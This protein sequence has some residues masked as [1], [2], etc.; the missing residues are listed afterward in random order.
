MDTNTTRKARIAL[1]G[2]GRIGRTLFRLNFELPEEEQFD[3]VVIKD[4]IPI[5]NMA[6]LLGHDSSY[7]NFP[8][9]IGFDD[10]NL[11]IGEQK[12]PYV[13]SFNMA[14]VDWHSYKPDIL[15]EASGQATA[16][17]MRSIIGGTITN[18]VYGRNVNDPDI[19]IVC[20]VNEH[21]YDPRN[22][23]IVSASSCTGN[24]LLPIVDV[25]LPAFGIES[26][27]AVSIHPV[28]GD[29]QLLDKSHQKFQLGRNAMRSIISTSSGIPKSV[30][31]LFPE[32]D[33]KVSAITYRVPTSIVSV[34]D[35]SMTLKKPGT[36]AE[37]KEALFDASNEKYAGI[38]AF[39]EGY[40]GHSKVSIDF[41]KSPYS[42]I[43]MAP[44][45]AMVQDQLT[46]SLIHDNE[47][48]YC[49]R[50]HQLIGYIHRKNQ[51]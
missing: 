23:A 4:I 34:I 12:I 38:I 47:W 45:T 14:D 28:L 13:Q 3:I 36:L 31:N 51:E 1:N 16:E 19:T 40:G 21:E 25:L 8:V 15:V 30:V 9:S 20:G 50:Y 27:H 44:D 2:F 41:V 24:A 48:G 6:Y 11:I 29:Q 10:T 18:V 37:V 49:S 35:V 42:V 26:M 32:L 39:D 17:E 5:E 33:G 22:H 43:I 46:L 7:G